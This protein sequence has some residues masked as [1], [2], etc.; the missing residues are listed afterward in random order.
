MGKKKSGRCE[1]CRMRTTVERVR[2]HGHL[3]WLCSGC[4][5]R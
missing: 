5:K 4:K 2:S 1:F 3:L